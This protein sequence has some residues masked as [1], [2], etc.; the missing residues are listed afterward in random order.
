MNSRSLK[1]GKVPIKLIEVQIG[2][3][4]GEDDITRDEDVRAREQGSRWFE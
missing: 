2:S 4:L 3:Y 1:P